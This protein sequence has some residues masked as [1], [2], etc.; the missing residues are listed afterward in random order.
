MSRRPDVTLT[1]LR[2][3][4]TAAGNGSMTQAAAELHVAQSAVSASIAELERQVGTQLF[5]RQ[6]GRGLIL[7]SAGEE[8]VRESQA[9]LAHLDEVLGSARGRSDQVRGH[10]RFACFTT[11]APFVLPELLADLAEHYPGLEVEVIEAEAEGLGAALRTGRAELALGYD[12]GLGPDIERQLVA[13]V[14][15]HV[16]LPAGHRLASHSRIHLED[17]A[18]EPMVLLD[19][20]HSTEYFHRLLASAGVEPT[21]RYRSVNYETVRGLVARGHGY[22]ILNQRPQHDIT[23]GGGKVEPRPIA[24]DLPPLRVVTAR[25][26]MARPTARARAIAARARLL[27]QTS[28][29]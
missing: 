10:I 17:L 2:Y 22:S 12:L 15:P 25:L 8:F 4:V 16:I 19:L 21:I 29:T 11:L 3:F 20:P 7:T 13:E 24:N 14:E 5:I 9:L 27:L 1:Q 18:S 28:W 6:P 26:S 23:Y